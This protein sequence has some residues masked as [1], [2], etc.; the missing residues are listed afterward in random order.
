M[1]RLFCKTCGLFAEVDDYKSKRRTSVNAANAPGW[2]SGLVCP[3]GHVAALFKSE[4]NPNW[5]EEDNER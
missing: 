5:E 2:S 1:M 4:V 3:C